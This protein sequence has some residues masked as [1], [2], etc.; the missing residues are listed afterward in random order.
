MLK[1]QTSSIRTTSIET[2]LNSSKF[3]FFRWHVRSN[4]LVLVL[5]KMF[6][7]HSRSFEIQKVSAE[8]S[9]KE[10]VQSKR[11]KA[12]K[13]SL[14]TATPSLHPLEQKRP[15]PDCFC[16][17]FVLREGGGH[18]QS[19]FINSDSLRLLADRIFSEWVDRFPIFSSP[20]Q[21]W[22]YSLRAER[23]LLWPF[24]VLLI[25]ARRIMQI[26]L[27]HRFIIHEVDNRH[28]SFLFPP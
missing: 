26:S 16:F 3:S 20:C 25:S 21:R 22:S 15:L 13:S 11:E 18:Q 19:I 7:D 23:N 9:H 14:C 1:R 10:K 24:T 8:E 2:K 4:K 28:F 17:C 27:S 6:I 5:L 12:P